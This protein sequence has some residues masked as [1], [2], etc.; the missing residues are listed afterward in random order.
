MYCHI[1]GIC[2]CNHSWLSLVF[3]PL[4]HWG[5]LDVVYSLSDFVDIIVLVY[6]C[7]VPVS[8]NCCLNV[9]FWVTYVGRGRCSSSSMMV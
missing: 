7:N 6:I 9:S 5:F 8:A 4:L 1:F 3:I 2:I